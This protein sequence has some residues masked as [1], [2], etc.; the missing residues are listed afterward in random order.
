[1]AFRVGDPDDLAQKLAWA[2]TNPDLAAQIGSRAS[3]EVRARYTI[4]AQ[5]NSIEDYL[6]DLQRET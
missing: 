4:E 3:E 1:V 5:V 2:L 6:R